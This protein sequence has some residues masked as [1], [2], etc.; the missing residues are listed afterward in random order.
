MILTNVSTRELSRLR[1]EL[2][3][4]EELL[5]YLRL[6]RDRMAKEL[7]TAEAPYLFWC[8]GGTQVLDGSFR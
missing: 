2:L 4:S 6:N 1:D 5:K 3:K 8:Q 7:R